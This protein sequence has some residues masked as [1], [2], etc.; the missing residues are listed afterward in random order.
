MAARSGP[1]RERVA[2]LGGG[3]AALTAALE[4]AKLDRYDITVFQMGWRLGGKGASGR[5]T[6]RHMRIEEHGLHIWFGAYD[7]AFRTIA[8]V[9]SRLYAIDPAKWPNGKVENAFTKQRGF[10][11]MEYCEGKW[12]PWHFPLPDSGSV[13]GG[14]SAP[15]STDGVCRGRLDPVS[16][17]QEARRWLA[18]HYRKF[19]LYRGPAPLWESQPLSLEESSVQ[20]ALAR[21]DPSELDALAEVPLGTDASESLLD[22]T[23]ERYRTFTN[24]LW[25]VVKL[26]LQSELRVAAVSTVEFTLLRRLWILFDVGQAIIRGMLESRIR[27]PEDWDTINDR[28]LRDWIQPLLLDESNLTSAVVAA[29]YSLFFSFPLG[30]QQ[31]MTEAGSATRAALWLLTGYT[32]A[33]MWRMNA[34]MGDTIFAPIYH[35]LRSPPFNVKFRFFHKVTALHLSPDGRS[36]ANI[37]CHQQA[38]MRNGD[39]EGYEP[40]V[41]DPMGLDCWPSTPKFALLNEGG[42]LESGWEDFNLESDWSQWTGGTEH[43]NFS[44]GADQTNRF[45]HVVLGIP[46]AAIPTICSPWIQHEPGDS[47][48][49]MCDHVSTVQTQAYQIWLSKD[50]VDLGS[51]L[52]DGVD[53][54]VATTYE[55]SI[56]TYCDMTHLRDHEA[57]PKDSK[58]SHI[59]YFCGVMLQEISFVATLPFPHFIPPKSD[60]LFAK[61]QF[62]R[63]RTNSIAMLRDSMRAIW[64]NAYSRQSTAFDWDLLFDSSQVGE[65]RFDDQ[66]YRANVDESERYVL[67]LPTTSACRLTGKESGFDNLVLAGDWTRNG[68]YMG[69]IE[70]A[71][72]SGIQAASDL[73]GRSVPL[74]NDGSLYRRTLSRSAAPSVASK[75]SAS[76]YVRRGGLDNPPPPWTCDLV[77][78]DIFVLEADRTALQRLCDRCLNGPGGFHYEPD[79]ILGRT[80]VSC[81][82]QHFKDMRSGSADCS[83]PGTYSYNEVCFWVPVRDARRGTSRE[84]FVPYI[85]VDEWLPLA[86]GRETYGYPKELA[87][88]TIPSDGTHP[89]KVTAPALVEYT[90]PPRAVQP[91][92]LVVCERGTALMGTES[93]FALAGKLIDCLRL[94][95]LDLVFLREF[96]ATAGSRDADFQE[97]VGAR[98]DLDA[99]FDL[100]HLSFSYQLTLATAA[101]HPIASDLGLTIDGNNRVDVLAAIRFSAPATFSAGR[102]LGP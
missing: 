52:C 46:V 60:K 18:Q 16:I 83:Q 36:I 92:D 47:I 51:T 41:T 63:T 21:L 58:P 59:A 53:R 23:V 94:V 70:G 82:F 77:T 8:D 10:H 25:T 14:T 42:A 29:N 48:R 31:A 6:Q 102:R 38:T 61:R 12:L 40:F 72:I 33:V 4:L 55:P 89:F 15:A 86:A 85:F 45:Q 5:N 93:T 1:G 87:A 65:S 57:W 17:N 97:I 50:N 79:E 27:R 99:P 91:V 28:E 76:E 7:N 9:Y 67:T 2:V 78:G 74:L 84:Y 66:F 44:V 19:G 101:S 37:E 81:T 95:S 68:L 22:D 98:A 90:S 34:G 71:A 100:G 24:S 11:L 35:V 80:L 3:M 13:P 73:S 49:T 96:R 69:C 64:P 56:D 62:G 75:S 20:Q 39:P 43:L 32:G 54:P 30:S 26:V 88:I